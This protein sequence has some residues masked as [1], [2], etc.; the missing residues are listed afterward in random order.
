MSL[1]SQSLVAVSLF[2]LA[3]V[4]ARAG[5]FFEDDFDRSTTQKGRVPEAMA[6]VGKWAG[7]KGG[8]LADGQ[9][10]TVT[11]AFCVSKPNAVLLKDE[12][13]T[14]G[15]S[16]AG[17]M[18]APV[19][20]RVKASLDFRVEETG[21]MWAI[22]LRA[23]SGA[24]GPYLLLRADGAMIAVQGGVTGKTAPVILPVLTERTWHRFEFILQP[25]EGCYALQVLDPAS[26]RVL[27]KFDKLEFDSK[28]F[29]QQGLS[30][31]QV[32]TVD[33]KQRGGSVAVDNYKV[34]SE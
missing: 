11:D 19:T 26:G 1:I 24:N 2:F 16:L 3:S 18:V 30:I 8:A 12:S 17:Q 21:M 32:Y 34:A 10:I 29:A 6:R 33:T 4:G 28:D 25:S 23:R 20:S 7:S 13:E 5:V 31:F 22:Q 14:T 15:V 9:G 27:A